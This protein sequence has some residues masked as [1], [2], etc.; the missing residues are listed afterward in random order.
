M[1]NQE[2]SLFHNDTA[3]HPLKEIAAY[4]KLWLGDTSFKKLANA[5]KNKKRPSMFINHIEYE[6]VYSQVMEYMDSVRNYYNMSFI[7]NGMFD[8]PE[9]LR[10]AKDPVEL[11]YFSGNI[12]LVNLKS[13]AIVGTRK[14]SHEGIRR[15]RQLVREFVKDNY[16]IVSGLAEGIDTVAHKSALHYNGITIGVI[17]TPLDQFYPKSNKDLQIAIAQNFLL[18]S[19]VPFL[20]YKRQSIRGNRLFFPER[21]KTMSAI[22]DATVI[23]EASDTSGTLIQA[24]AALDQG[25]KLFILNSC[26]ENRKI[27]WPEKFESLGAIRVREFDDIRKNLNNL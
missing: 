18:I 19:Q 14:P 21:N 8:Y 6:S 3:I 15:T 7:M 23:V 26:F 12:D 13:V 22:S 11:L 10:Q 5:F 4:E 2:L 9:K 16:V 17:G 24:R 20:K 1:S 27:S 25:R